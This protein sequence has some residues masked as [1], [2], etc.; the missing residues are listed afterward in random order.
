MRHGECDA[1]QGIEG[2]A[3]SLNVSERFLYDVKFQ[4]MLSQIQQPYSIRGTHI[5]ASDDESF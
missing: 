1:S 3:L 5:Q 2:N 4:N